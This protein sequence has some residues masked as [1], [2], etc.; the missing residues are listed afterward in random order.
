VFHHVVLMKFS[1]NADDDFFARVET[2]CQRIR[3]NGDHPL[4]Y[5]FHRNVAS[6][7]DGLDYGIVASF[8]SSSAHD[9][10]Q[11]SEVH[12]EMKSYMSP[13]IERIVVCDIDEA[14]K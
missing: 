12:Q 9:V 4:R 14:S 1:P 13:F 5:V 7:S 3:A 8:E 6:R 10:Y 2:Y 11:L